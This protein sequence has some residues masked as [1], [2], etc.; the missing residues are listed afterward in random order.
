MRPEKEPRGYLDKIA[1][2]YDGKKEDLNLLLSK[3]GIVHHHAGLCSSESTLGHLSQDE[4]LQEL[5]HQENELVKRG[6]K[7]LDGI[8]SSMC[9]LDAG[10]GRGGSSFLL[11]EKFGCSVIGINI[12]LYQVRFASR[13]TKDLDVGGKVNF[14]HGDMLKAP[15][16]D[17]AFDFVWAC[18]STGYVLQLREMFQEFGRLLNRDGRLLVFATCVNSNHPQCGWY[19]NQIDQTYQAQIHSTEEYLETSDSGLSLKEMVNLTSETIPYWELRAKSAHK[20]GVE[21][22]VVGAKTGVLEY[23]LFLYKKQAYV[24]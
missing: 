13:V 23:R 9:G 19:K 12:S 1:K 4:I 20:T 10:C 24:K 3:D 14:Y 16:K 22:L 15:F 7:Y 2:Y 5:Y 17:G 18:E 21:D 11:H 6:M 8:K